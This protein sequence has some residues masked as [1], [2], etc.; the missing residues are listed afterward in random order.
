MTKLIRRLITEDQGQD[1]IEY[2]LL[3]AFIAL[4]ATVA[5]IALGGGISQFFTSV[6]QQLNSA[7][8]QAGS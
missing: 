8:T 6:T 4:A 1:L 7:S 5:M 2:A 3:A